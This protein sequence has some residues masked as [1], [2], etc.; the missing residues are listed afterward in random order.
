MK[1]IYYLYKAI[2]SYNV[3][4]FPENFSCYTPDLHPAYPRPHQ[5]C[6]LLLA[7]ISK[8]VFETPQ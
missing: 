1:V 6:H 3:I 7:V 4:I 2:D 8:K 5:N